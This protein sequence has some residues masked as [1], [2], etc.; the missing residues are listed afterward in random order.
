MVG[1]GWA[2]TIDQPFVITGC[3]ERTVIFDL[4]FRMEVGDED[5]VVIREDV[6]GRRP[7]WKG[8]TRAIAPV[9]QEDASLGGS[10][11]P[12]RDQKPAPGNEEA[13]PALFESTADDLDSEEESRPVKRMI[14]WILVIEELRAK[15]RRGG[16]H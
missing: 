14:D 2:T 4:R 15:H 5:P 10:S 9:K 3:T 13:L 8:V 11:S 7:R 1:E 16:G 12:S 6:I